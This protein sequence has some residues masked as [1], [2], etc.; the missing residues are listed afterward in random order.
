MAATI[1]ARVLPD[2]TWAN[3]NIQKGRTDM[4]AVKMT[5]FPPSDTVRRDD[6]VSMPVSLSPLALLNVN[7]AIIEFGYDARLYCNGQDANGTWDGRSE[8]CVKGN[9]SGTSYDFAGDAVTGVA[10]T[11]SCTVTIPAIAQ[12]VLYWRVV[13]RNAVN[14]VISRG[15]INTRAVN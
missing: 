3:V 4:W 12:R 8:I 7:N 11:S 10:C 15:Q 1:N 6:F 9:Q 14:A 5:G 13:Y 2:A